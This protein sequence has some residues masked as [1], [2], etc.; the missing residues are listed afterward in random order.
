MKKIIITILF[1][2]F[3]YIAQAQL[4]SN[5]PKYIIS[6]INF[7]EKNPDYFTD[8]LVFVMP[9]NGKVEAIFNSEDYQKEEVEEKMFNTLKSAK[10]IKEN[11]VRTYYLH[12]NWLKN[13]LPM[14][15]VDINVQY[16]PYKPDFTLGLPFGLDYIGGKFAPE[17][18]FRAVVNLKK[19]GLG[20]SFTNSFFFS[21]K[22]DGGVNVFHNPFV[23]AEIVLSPSSAPWNTIQVGYLLNNS[24]PVF[25]GETIKLA[26]R[27][28]IKGNFQLNAGFIITDNIKTIIPTVG[29]RFF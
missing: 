8:T 14:A 3:S 6:F 17:M 29:F 10:N 16:V 2:S 26:Y 4:K 1:C 13:T 20:A 19:V 18:G 27:Y 22:P 23:N 15:L 28:H 24:G 11:E 25:Q 21:D 7:A 5:T 12:S 9:N